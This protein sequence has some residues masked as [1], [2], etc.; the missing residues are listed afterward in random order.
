MPARFFWKSGFF[1]TR[2]SRNPALVITEW[3]KVRPLKT[4]IFIG[5]PRKVTFFWDLK[6]IW[7]PFG[8][9]T[10]GGQIK[11]AWKPQNRFVIAA[12]TDGTSVCRRTWLPLA[13]QQSHFFMHLINQSESKAL[14]WCPLNPHLI[15]TSHTRSSLM[16]IALQK[17][18]LTSRISR[19]EF[20]LFRFFRR[21][22][23]DLSSSN[24]GQWNRCCQFTTIT[25][26]FF[27]WQCQSIQ[28]I[29]R[30][31]WRHQFWQTL[32]YFGLQWLLWIFQTQCQKKTHLPMPGWNWNVHDWQS[33]QESMPG[34][35]VEELNFRLVVK[36]KSVTLIIN[37][38]I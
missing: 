21:R 36:R 33:A 18:N 23:W 3:T 1:T 5:N 22:S 28:S 14:S 13:I 11:F 4:P 7:S 20:L 27:D 12:L 19:E 16:E 37:Q 26:H 8:V 17:P 31:L 2:R 25:T 29:M 6:G 34:L 35:Q 9:S 15:L 24:L 38:D 10:Q 30:C 32:W